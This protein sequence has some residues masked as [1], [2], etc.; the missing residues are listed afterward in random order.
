MNTF[1]YKMLDRSF[2]VFG[3]FAFSQ[4]PAFMQQYT[5]ILY[6]HVQECKRLQMA[7]EL[8]ATVSNKTV[9]EYIQKFLIQ[10]DPDFVHQ[11][12][13]LLA[14]QERYSTLSAA[15]THLNTA[16]I[17]KR[18]FV[19]FSELDMSIVHE[20][21]SQFTLSISF[22][23]ETIIFM[24]IGILTAAGILR[25]MAWGARSIFRR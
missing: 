4:M 17:W 7:L 25:F 1:F 22:S 5:Q 9:S 15:Y 19:F 3:A 21:M 11:G 12:K 13:L 10:Q 6:G 8:H 23:L 24:L 18:P 2:A 16:A 20:T 14:I